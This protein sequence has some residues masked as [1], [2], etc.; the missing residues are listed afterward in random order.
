MEKRGIRLEVDGIPILGE[1]YIPTGGATPV[2]PSLCIC[3]G[4]PAGRP[5]DPGDRGYPLLAERY[6]DAGFITAIFNFRG[7]G[8]SGGNIDLLGWTRDLK[9][10][11]D[12]LYGLKEVNRSF[13]G[14]MGFSGGAA[15]SVYVAAQDL[16][17][18]SVITCACP[19]EFRFL[20]KTGNLIEHFRRIKLIRDNDFPPS[21]EEWRE[22]FKQ[23]TPLLWIDQISPRPLLIIHGDQDE[24]VEVSHAWTLYHR[25]R[26]PKEIVI[27]EGGEH[28]LRLNENAMKIALEWLLRKVA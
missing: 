13:F 1:V 23:V 14:V 2:Y 12:Y 5:A 24:V 18:T 9:A 17:V 16:R 4:I 19:A 6:C 28:K 8:A 21:A 10:V 26:E 22:N 11:L 15:V 3:H 20:E 25:A 27:V 7:T